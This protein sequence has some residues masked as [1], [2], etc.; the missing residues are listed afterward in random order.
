MKTLMVTGYKPREIN[1]F[2]ENDQKIHII[3]AAMEKRLIGFI[4]EGLEWIL[5]SGQMG[6]ELWTAE[7]VLD[8]K[9]HYDIQLAIIPP[10]ENQDERWPEDIKLKYEELTMLADFYQPLYKGDYKGPYQFRAKNKWLVEKS[11]G[12]LLLLDEE[13]PGSIKFF[14]EE[15][16]RAQKDYSI[17][18]ITPSDLDDMVEEIRM[19]DPNYWN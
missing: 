18:F 19:S 1:I 13:Y 3:K 15:A 8:L 14:Y 12:C 11:D 2:K 9:D 16:K 4:E 5:I 10:F 17:Y 7:I 6:V